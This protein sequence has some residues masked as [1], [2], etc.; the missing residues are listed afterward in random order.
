[1]AGSEPLNPFG[2]SGEKSGYVMDCV[3]RM[4]KAG[5]ASDRARL[6]GT[7]TA[8]LVFVAIL[9]GGADASKVDDSGSKLEVSTL[10]NEIDVDG[11]GK[12]D[13]NEV[14]AEFF[15]SEKGALPNAARLF[16]LTVSTNSR[17]T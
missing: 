2:P 5:R 10:F 12:L 9:L 7:G 14:K 16:S 17:R 8:L 3:S 4:S 1:M 15:V 6:L 11:D 13:W